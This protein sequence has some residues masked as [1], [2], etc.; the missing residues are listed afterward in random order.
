VGAPSTGM[1]ALAYDV[2][3]I[4]IWSGVS[5]SW[6]ISSSNSIGEVDPA[7]GAIANFT[8]L[9][10]GS[11][12]LF[13]NATYLGNTVVK[14]ML[15]NVSSAPTP[16]P[17]SSPSY[18]TP[19]YATPSYSTPPSLTITPTSE[20]TPTPTPTPIACAITSGAWSTAT[21]VT[22][23]DTVSLTVTTND[24]PSCVGKKIAFEVWE[25]DSPV[26]GLTDE[27][28]AKHP[29]MITLSGSS[30][31]TTWVAE[32]QCDGDILGLCTFGLPEYYFKANI[33]GEQ[34]EV[35]SSDP[36]LE[37]NKSIDLVISSTP[38]VSVTENTANISWDTSKESS[39]KVNYGVTKTRGKSTLEKDIAVRTNSHSVVLTNLN[40]CTVYHYTVY[41]KDDKAVE[42]ESTPSTF[43]TSGCDATVVESKE[44]DT[45]IDTSL[46]G[47]LELLSTDSYGISLSIPEDF[48]T[49]NA[50]FQILRLNKD[51]FNTKVTPPL[52]LST[53]GDYV[54]GLNAILSD[55]ESIATTFDKEITVTIYYDQ[56]LLTNIDESSLTIQRWDGV[57]WNTLTNCTPDTT[58]NSISCPTTQFSS[59]VLVGQKTEEPTPTLTPVPAA[60][61]NTPSSYGS[62]SYGS[63]SYGSPSYG[64]PSSS[65]NSSDLNGDGKVN[66]FDLSILLRNWNKSG[67]GDLN[68]DG[69]VNI[70]DLST[71]LRNWSK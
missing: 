7:N 59:F 40:S 8:P 63:P 5:Y 11:G 39:S 13:V 38:Q 31:T 4:P 48:L 2:N 21:P 71:L 32:W 34:T 60:G 35:T 26:K 15:V 1:S 43:V 19:S 67:Q 12:D 25:S 23:G 69:K 45:V 17:T 64:T 27:R 70:F 28:A 29:P 51:E 42:K 49:F 33:E 56:S 53:I 3:N 55:E 47:T 9:N 18:S 50:N 37:V 65:S 41:S 44:T 30:A 46:G 16:T 6:G 62:P 22:E 57:S 66:I 24:A 61:Y 58:L 20:P 14:S 68:S 36:L 10:A 52:N 54:Y